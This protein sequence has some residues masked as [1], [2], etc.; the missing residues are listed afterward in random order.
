MVR[1][2]LPLSNRS[3]SPF[4]ITLFQKSH[5]S[6]SFSSQPHQS[7]TTSSQH[8]SRHPQWSLPYSGLIPWL[9]CLRFAS[10]P[11]FPQYDKLLQA[12]TGL[13]FFGFLQLCHPIARSPE[14]PLNDVGSLTGLGGSQDPVPQCTPF[15]CVSTPVARLPELLRRAPCF[16]FLTL[17]QGWTKLRPLS[18]GP[19]GTTQINK[20]SWLSTFPA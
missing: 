19:L 7:L 15:L 4:L 9:C 18:L 1:S 16:L 2:C 17:R 14:L 10:T 20:M 3:R 13:P 12:G 8:A 5:P 6:E 11:S